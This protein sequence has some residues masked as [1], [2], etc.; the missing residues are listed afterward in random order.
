[1]SKNY[2]NQKSNEASLGKE[3]NVYSESAGGKN[4]KPYDNS[5]GRMYFEYLQGMKAYDED[6]SDY[7]TAF[8]M[9]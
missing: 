8:M 6:E 7:S 4:E 9:A 3:L 5:P 2:F 1:M